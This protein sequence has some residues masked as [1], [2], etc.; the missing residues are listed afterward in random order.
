LAQGPGKQRCEAVEKALPLRTTPDLIKEHPQRRS[1][2]HVEDQL[3]T[4]V[5]IDPDVEMKYDA[6]GVADPLSSTLSLKGLSWHR[7]WSHQAKEH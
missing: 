4:A 2:T 7:V 5:P 3:S 1:G 6:A